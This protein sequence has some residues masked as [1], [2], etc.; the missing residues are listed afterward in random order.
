MSPFSVEPLERR[1]L[2][3]GTLAT[4]YTFVPR[5]T[6]HN[7]EMDYISLPDGK[8]ISVG[9][10]TQDNGK[11]DVVLTR[12]QPP[13][14][15]ANVA[16][17]DGSFGIGGIVTI[18]LKGS[19]VPF[20]LWMQDDGKP[21]VVGQTRRG[22]HTVGLLVRL[23]AD[24][25]LDQTFGAG[26]IVTLSLDHKFTRFNALSLWRGKI[27]VAGTAGNDILVARFDGDGTLDHS[28]NDNGIVR[29]NVGGTDAGYGLYV[30]TDG[31]TVVAGA[32]AIRRRGR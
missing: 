6:T 25:S 16:A 8:R 28:F 3:S 26:G 23:N 19:S 20:A 29:E 7:Q 32:G 5:Y 18:S 17:M 2:L 1:T 24:G 11:T 22:A 27:V 12:L 10:T 14:S 4:P 15:G 13:D 30:G 9:F 21:V 31:R